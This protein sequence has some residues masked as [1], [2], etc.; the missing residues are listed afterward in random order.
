MGHGPHYSLPAEIYKGKPI[1][2]GLGSFSFHT[3]H[4]G[5]KHG[6]WMGMM[7]TATIDNNA[8][9]KTSIKLVRHNDANE[10]YFCDPAQEGEELA[11]SHSCR[12]WGRSWW[13]GM[14]GD[15]CGVISARTW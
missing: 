7:V 8:I 15:R 2:Y 6:N 1:F 13:Q 9:T 4:G 14:I 5:K 12:S 10:S 3:G 11:G